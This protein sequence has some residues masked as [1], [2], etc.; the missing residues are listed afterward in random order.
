[1]IEPVTELTNRSHDRTDGERARSRPDHRTAGWWRVE[2]CAGG[3][4]WDQAV[5]TTV[6]RMEGWMVHMYSYVPGL[7]KVKL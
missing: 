6:P 3:R 4:T 1:M 7:V 2:G 5:T